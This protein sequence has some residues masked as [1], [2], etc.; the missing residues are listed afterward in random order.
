MATFKNGFSGNVL[1]GA[2][3]LAVTEWNCDFEVEILDTTTTGDSGWQTNINGCKKATGTVKT[4]FDTAAV[5]TGATGPNLQNGTSVT[6]TLKIAD[7]T[8]V[9]IV[10]ARIGKVSI[11]NPVKGVVSFEFPFESNGVCTLPT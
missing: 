2:Y 4:F 1:V 10:P 7:T 3:S 8:S 11:G 6:L 5:P 9:C